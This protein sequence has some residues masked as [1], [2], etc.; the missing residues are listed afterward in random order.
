MDLTDT[1]AAMRRAAFAARKSAQ[2][3]DDGAAAAVARRLV[4]SGL[5]A[6]AAVVSGYRPIRTEI[7]PTPA[8]EAMREGGARLCVPVIEGKGRPLV[9]REWWPGCEMVEGTFGAEIPAE[10]AVLEPDLLLVPLLAF[11]ALGWRLG[12]GGGFYDRTLEGL[13]QRK[14]VRAIG[15]AY[16]AQEV[17]A[18]PTEPTDQR[19]DAVVTE[20]GL[21]RP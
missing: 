4:A 8:M 14:A 7:D 18:V 6:G 11:D 1:K 19:L 15:L 12:Y 3:A 13:R 16:A 5:A 9:F 20:H 2:Q 10:G 21:I 17:E